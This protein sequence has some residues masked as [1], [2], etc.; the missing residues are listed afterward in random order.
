MQYDFGI[1]PMS[2]HTATLRLSSYDDAMNSVFRTV[3]FDPLNCTGIADIKSTIRKSVEVGKPAK[4]LGELKTAEQTAFDKTVCNLMTLGS[5]MITN[6]IVHS[7]CPVAVLG[8]V[9]GT[10][11]VFT[12]DDYITIK[13]EIDAIPI[14][15]IPSIDHLI[16]DIVGTTLLLEAPDPVREFPGSKLH[17]YVPFLTLAETRAVVTTLAANAH[18]F[19]SYC[20]KLGIATKRWNSAICSLRGPTMKINDWENFDS[21][22]WG[23]NS[24]VEFK[25]ATADQYIFQCNSVEAIASV[26]A[27]NW[28]Q[29]KQY[30]YKQGSRPNSL[31]NIIRM[32]YPYGA[33]NLVGCTEVMDKTC[34]GITDAYANDDY[35][36][37]SV[38]VNGTDFDWVT[39]STGP[40]IIGS[41]TGINKN[42]DTLGAAKTV[43]AAPQTTNIALDHILPA[44]FKL[45]DF[46]PA[47]SFWD[48]SAHNPEYMFFANLFQGKAAKNP[49]GP[50]EEQLKRMAA[51]E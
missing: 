28:L 5:Q 46:G 8:M 9:S 31:N 37:A 39:L 33:E 26:G 40:E 16:A 10:D 6:D 48:N 13:N 4:A 45:V 12:V 38:A 11:N 19:E 7:E 15:S 29:Y 20:Q 17:F 44:D 41:L 1:T 34:L 21:Q 49:S 23:L 27:E 42:N 47:T 30:M 18:L 36:L 43:D 14:N 2:P 32:F 24:W 3:K 51:K 50:T 22:F 25:N 35:S